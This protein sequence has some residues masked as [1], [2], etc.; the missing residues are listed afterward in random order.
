[1]A[2]SFE[3]IEKVG[4]S[5]KCSCDAIEQLIK[6]V[7]KEK[8]VSWFEVKEER[9]RVDENGDIEFQVT[10]KIGIKC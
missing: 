2:K 9:G 10:L 7:N 3:I 6:N 1:M 5:K 8:K 4:I